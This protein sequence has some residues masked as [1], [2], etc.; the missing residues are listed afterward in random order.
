MTPQGRAI[1]ETTTKFGN[2]KTLPFTPCKKGYQPYHKISGERLYACMHHNKARRRR[3]L[4]NNAL[5]HRNGE[6]DFNRF[7]MKDVYTE[8]QNRK[9]DS[10][11]NDMPDG[12]IDKQSSYMASTT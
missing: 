4:R 5:V 10:E 1:H 6:V 7:E 11:M 3:L 8:S 2:G 9:A 12:K